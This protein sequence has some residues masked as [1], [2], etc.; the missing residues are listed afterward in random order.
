LYATEEDNQIMLQ[1]IHAVQT[2]ILYNKTLSCKDL[3]AFLAWSPAV[4]NLQHVVKYAISSEISSGFT[5]EQMRLLEDTLALDIHLPQIISRPEKEIVV[6]QRID[7]PDS[8]ESRLT[9]SRTCKTSKLSS[10]PVKKLVHN[11]LKDCRSFH[12]EKSLPSRVSTFPPLASPPLRS[13]PNA[14]EYF[15]DKTN[16]LKIKYETVSRLGVEDRDKDLCEHIITE[17]ENLL[18]DEDNLFSLSIS[19]RK[20]L[21]EKLRKAIIKIRSL[22]QEAIAYDSSQL[23]NQLSQTKTRTIL[24]YFNRCQSL[25]LPN[26]LRNSLDNKEK[27]D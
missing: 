1:H 24:H 27:P 10:L 15:L 22:L 7:S 20:Y 9:L 8:S 13:L 21:R 19:H 12:S 5:K 26:S 25:N 16:D 23:P 17:S 11:K 14:L 6:Y 3:H 4:I 2:S 18:N